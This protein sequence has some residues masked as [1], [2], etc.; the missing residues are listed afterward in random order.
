MKLRGLRISGSGRYSRRT[1][2][3]VYTVQFFVTYAVA[4]LTNKF[5]LAATP[6]WNVKMIGA[7][8]VAGVFVTIMMMVALQDRRIRSWKAAGFLV[9]AL[10]ML[11]CA[12]IAAALGLQSAPSGPLST[13]KIVGWRWNWYLNW[14]LT[15][16]LG[17]AYVM[18]WLAVRAKVRTTVA[19]RLQRRRLQRGPDFSRI[20]RPAK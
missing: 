20:S 5:E 17:T 7:G 19:R 1:D 15:V 14:Y 13:P 2:I 11:L 10:F 8:I 12:G 16:T 3:A 6:I 18:L 4:D 9:G